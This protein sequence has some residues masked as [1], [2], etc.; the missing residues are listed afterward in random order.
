MCSLRTNIPL[1][2]WVAA[3]VK[4]NMINKA[5]RNLNSQEYEYFVPRRWETVKTGNGFRRVQKL[6]FPG[7]VFVRCDVKS[8]DII[9]IN[10]TLGLSRIIKA[11][12]C[13][14]AIIPDGFIEELKFACRALEVLGHGMR[15][16]D[17]V[18]LVNGPFVGMIGEVMNANDNG[19]LKILFELMTGLRELTLDKTWVEAVE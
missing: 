1:L 17:K 9:R 2:N 15:K 10:S 18:R 7:Y 13:S 8:E 12:G 16:G 19:R 5:C 4:P 14:P 6:L 11:T 3:Q